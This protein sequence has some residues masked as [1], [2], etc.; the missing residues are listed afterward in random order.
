MAVCGSGPSLEDEEVLAVLKRWKGLI[1]CGATNAM[2]L[3]AH[4]IRPHFI[5]VVDASAE[6]TTYLRQVREVPG[7]EKIALLLPVTADPSAALEWP[8]ARY[9]NLDFIQSAGGLQNP[10]NDFQTKMLPFVECWLTQAGCVANTAT[11]LAPL[12]GDEKSCDITRTF[13]FGCDF[14]YP[15][16]DRV[17]YLTE[18]KVED[19]HAAASYRVGRYQYHS[20]TNSFSRVQPVCRPMEFLYSNGVLTESSNFGYKRSLYTV[21]QVMFPADWSQR[22]AGQA[23]MYSCSRGILEDFFPAVRPQDACD[24]IPFYDKDFVTARYTAYMNSSAISEGSA[25]KKG[26]HVE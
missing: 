2:A 26:D 15:R 25:E 5:M 23:C 18:P 6:L 12:W 7:S 1:I 11:M 4:G 17:R 8:Y 24:D 3:L 10:F 20:L 16:K 19:A 14:G 9:W 22:H 13:L 21:W